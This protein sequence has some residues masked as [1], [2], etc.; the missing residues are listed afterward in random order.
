MSDLPLWAT[1]SRMDWVDTATGKCGGA[2]GP[3]S[4]IDA[5]GPAATI[6]R[7]DRPPVNEDK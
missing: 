2:Y 5:R 6:V 4:V 7:I 3:G 1:H